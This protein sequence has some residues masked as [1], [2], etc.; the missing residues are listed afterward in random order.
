MSINVISSKDVYNIIRKTM[1][2]MNKDIMKHGEITGYILYKMLQQDG[3]Y[4]TNE[5]AE[6]AM[7]GLMHDIGVIKTGYKGG[8]IS[9]ETTNLWAHS[10][11]GY[12]FLNRLSPVGDTARLVLYHHLD[13]TMHSSIQNPYWKETEYLTLADKMDVFMRMKGHGM[14]NDYFVENADITFSAAALKAFYAAQN[15]YSILEKL[16]TG[17]YQQELSD[18]FA[19]VHFTENYKK[20]LLGM[21]IYAIDFRSYQTVVHSLATTT[22]ATSIARLMRLQSEELQIIYYGA[23]LHDIGKIAIPLEIL[24]A[25]RRLNDDE[26]RIMK[27]HVMITEKIL[28][29]IIDDEVLEVSIR[30][31]EKLDGTGYHR[32]LKGDEITQAQ[33]IVA[34]ADI[35]S[36]LYGK[37]SYKESFSTEKI[38]SILQEDAD[39]GKICDKIT[40]VVVRNLNNILKEFE[41][42]KQETIGLYEGILKEYD[43]I[44]ELFKHLD[45]AKK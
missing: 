32:G 9:V 22:F 30:H 13:Y 35:L 17:E 3:R 34:V 14:Q 44:Y 16:N 8:P 31:H 27:A 4:S 7:I 43:E 37:R 26:M 28:R 40:G 25:P 38:I 24:E 19:S 21:L 23:L 2:I 29:G 39:A 12:L 20:R 33:R 18:L 1:E 11:Y 41:K 6:Y 10:I 15:K 45:K 5:L 36:A 42:N